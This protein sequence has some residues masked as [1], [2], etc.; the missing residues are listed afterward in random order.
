M[1]PP[2]IYIYTLAVFL[3]VG[4]LFA[5]PPQRL[6]IEFDAPLS[7]EQKMGLNRKIL[8]IIKSDIS[9]LPHSTEQRWIVVINPPLDKSNIDKSIEEISRLE[10]VKYVEPDM[11]MHPPR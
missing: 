3:Q 2:G 10:H 7:A 9:V 5:A 4:M 1:N 8:S 11:L 6:I